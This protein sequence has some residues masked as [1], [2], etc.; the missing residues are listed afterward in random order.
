ML[1]SSASMTQAA[2]K[3]IRKWKSQGRRVL[4]YTCNYTPEEI[5]YA[6]SILPTRIFGSLGPTKAA[7]AL[8]PVNVCSFAKSCLDKALKQEYT[9][10]DGLVF[11]SCC[12]NQNKIYDLWRHCT[13]TQKSYFMN[14]PHSKTATSLEFFCQ[15]LERFRDWLQETFDTQISEKSLEKAIMV[16]N[17][18]RRL[19][20]QVYDL[21]KPNPPLLS[22]SEA[23]D[24]VL[25]SMFTSKEEHNRFLGGLLK[26]SQKR[27]RVAPGGARLLVSGSALDNSELL[28]LVESVRGCV[29]A[30]DLCTGSR[31]FWNVVKENGN[32]LRAIAERYLSNIPCP[33]RYNS[34]ERLSHLREIIRLYSVE[35]IL[36]F[37]L[38]CC[39]THLFDAPLLAEELRE[40]EGLPVLLLEWEHSLTGV[41]QLRTRIEAF[42]ETLE[43]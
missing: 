33:F 21:R 6:G 9:F 7:D 19:L 5:V 17:E 37:S 36:I 1:A 41:G 15:E 40:A 22:G 13:S 28:K 14:T 20:R 35:A 8:L 2:E 30:D 12:D 31:Y 29:V 11:S 3:S 24:I 32:P 39:D 34:E 18:N 25:S 42:I 43:E 27:S 4:G 23:L 16:S 10:L 38:K 26:E